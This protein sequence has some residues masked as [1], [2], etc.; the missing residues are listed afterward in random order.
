MYVYLYQF[1]AWILSPMADSLSDQSSTSNGIHVRMLRAL[2]IVL[3][4]G[5][6]DISIEEK[7]WQKVCKSLLVN[8][9]AHNKICPE[10]KDVMEYF[11][12]KK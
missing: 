5:E 10:I 2:C 4:C 12:D 1:V 9:D 6:V 3:V 7:I 8:A 11:A